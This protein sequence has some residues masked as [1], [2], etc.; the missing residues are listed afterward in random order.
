[1]ISR[2]VFLAGIPFSVLGVVCCFFLREI[3][4]FLNNETVFGID[5]H[6]KEHDDEDGKAIEANEVT[7]VQVEN[8]SKT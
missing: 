6:R 8:V 1:M 4:A 7:D 3:T 5:H 2:I